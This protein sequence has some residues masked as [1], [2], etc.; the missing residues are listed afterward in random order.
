M[1]TKCPGTDL[2]P[3]GDA[4]VAFIRYLTDHPTL[5]KTLITTIGKRDFTASSIGRGCLTQ[6]DALIEYEDPT[7]PPTVVSFNMCSLITW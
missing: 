4:S 3:T 6:I 2:L 7:K 1:S 5:Q